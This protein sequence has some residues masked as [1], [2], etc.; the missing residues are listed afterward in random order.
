MAPT[1]D[2]SHFFARRAAGSLLGAALASPVGLVAA[3]GALA[4]VA[5][6]DVAD[7]TARC[8]VVLE[9]NV[10]LRCGDMDRFYRV[11]TAK[12]GTVLRLDGEGGGWL[13]IEYPTTLDTL[14]PVT[15]GKLSADGK[16]VEIVAPTRLR[17][18]NLAKGFRGSFK[19]VLT[20]PLTPGTI[21]PLVEA[22]KGDDGA[23]VAFAVRPPAGARAYINAQFVRAATE[24]EAKDYAAKRGAPGSILASPENFVPNAETDPSRTEPTPETN[25]QPPAEGGSLADPMTPPADGG[26]PLAPVNPDAGT[27]EGGAPAPGDAEATPAKPSVPEII[28]ELENKYAAVRKQPMDQAEWEELLAEHQSLLES[29]GDAPSYARLR[30]QL[31]A[32]IAAIDVRIRYRDEMQALEANS[33]ERRSAVE[34]QRRKIEAAERDGGYTLIGRLTASAIYDGGRLPLLFALRS[35]E[36]QPRTLA[37]IDPG[38]DTQDVRAYLGQTI[39]I[40][41]IVRMAPDLPIKMITP[42]RIDSIDAGRP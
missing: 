29:L 38:D 31:E 32:R 37:Y 27:T 42:A 10:P 41:G 23:V 6:A 7:V 11:G 25:M 9:D 33:A 15:E 24:A 8:V 4:P 40:V 22:V 12:K 26:S 5:A 1:R 19:S 30:R 35:V 3:A 28:R 34:E 14:V 20:E 39:G 2:R 16:S 21:L 17:A 36:G 18:R 13:R